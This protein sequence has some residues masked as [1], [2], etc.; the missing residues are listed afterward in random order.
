MSAM[1][2]PLRAAAIGVGHFGQHHARKLAES[3]QAELVAVVD[4]EPAR[5]AEVAARHGAESLADHR[6]LLGRVDVVCIATPPATHHAIA[7]D[8]LLQGAHVFVEKPITV[9]LQEAEE[10]IAL[11]KAKGRVLQ[12]GH[13]ERFSAVGARIGTMIS[14]PLFIQAQRIGLSRPR[15]QAV[16]AVLDLMIHDLDLILSLV[17]APIKW[18][19]ALGA[20][21]VTAAD[22]VANCRLEFA[23]GCVAD[24]TASRVSPRSE[25]KMRIFERDCCIAV[26]FLKRRITVFRKIGNKG[27]ALPEMSIE[28]K[29]YPAVD[30][31]AAEI[32]SFLEAARIGGAPVVSGEDGRL[33]LE[34]ALLIDREIEAHRRRVEAAAAGA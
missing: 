29:V 9:T 21:V 24:L 26:D 33:A 20:P 7:R 31:L 18:A 2:R 15:G 16:S 34:A 27:G 5:A 1:K 3:S 23:G 28:D 25:R 4:P 30:A 11:A 8:F 32:E 17:R 10:L 12:V 22:D 19:H 13:I 6:P 14:R